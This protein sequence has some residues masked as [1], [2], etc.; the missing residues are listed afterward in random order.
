MVFSS[1]FLMGLFD[2][3]SPGS[4]ATRPITLKSLEVL[5]YSGSLLTLE[6]DLARKYQEP[7]PVSLPT[8]HGEAN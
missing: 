5:P 6:Q 7:G 4:T 8:L 1:G 2:G 3:S